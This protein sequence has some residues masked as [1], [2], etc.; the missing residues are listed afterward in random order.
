MSKAKHFAFDISRVRVFFK[1]TNTG[2]F[3]GLF[4]RVTLRVTRGSFTGK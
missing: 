3:N 2:L 4:T 1:G